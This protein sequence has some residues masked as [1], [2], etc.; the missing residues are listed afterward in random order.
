MAGRDPEVSAGRRWLWG[1]P[2]EPHQP[3]PSKLPLHRG[4]PSS[5]PV[6]WSGCGCNPLAPAPCSKSR[7]AK[8]LPQMDGMAKAG[9]LGPPRVSGST[10]S[11]Y[12]YLLSS[13]LR[14]PLHEG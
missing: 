8:A 10:L 6:Q 7:E 9:A 12:T 11:P 4:D 5:Q 1:G 2:D 3:L 13:R 14:L